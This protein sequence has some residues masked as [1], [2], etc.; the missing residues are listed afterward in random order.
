LGETDFQAEISKIRAVKPAAIFVFA[1]D[2]MAPA[3][4]KQW[5]AS[6]LGK[7]IKLFSTQTIDWLTLPAIGEPAI[8]A[9]EA[10]QWGVD[11]DNETNKAF[12]KD[13]V[14][15]FNHTPSNFAQ[16]S[17]DAARLIAAGVKAVSGRVGDV[18][19][20]MKT[21]RKV[22]YPSARGAYA[23][24]VNGIPIQTFYKV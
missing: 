15:E 8:G 21:M 19:A 2:A 4:V 22:S 7:E 5:A 20:L 18:A 10:I 17:Y 12:V 1:P 13:Y 16:Q 6:G 24:N 9:F 3:F 23:Y 11:L 14:A